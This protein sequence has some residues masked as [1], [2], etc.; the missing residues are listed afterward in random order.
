MSMSKE[1]KAKEFAN[2]LEPI[3]HIQCP[4]DIINPGLYFGFI[5]GWEQNLEILSLKEDLRLMKEIGVD[6]QRAINDRQYEELIRY[7]L[8]LEECKNQRDL[9]YSS[10]LYE[11]QFDVTEVIESDNKELI[12]ILK[13]G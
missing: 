7:K 13:G 3:K 10:L 8:A 6:M 4:R 1:E 2:S 5:E 9:A 11:K 12:Q